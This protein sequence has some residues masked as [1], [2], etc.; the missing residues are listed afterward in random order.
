MSVYKLYTDMIFNKFRCQPLFFTV[1]KVF[2]L[3]CPSDTHF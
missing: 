1:S 3:S 2:E